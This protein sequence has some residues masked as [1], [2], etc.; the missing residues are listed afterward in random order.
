MPMVNSRLGDQV[1]CYHADLINIYNSDIGSR[2]KIGDFTEIGGATVGDDTSI[3]AFCYISPGT[4][5]GNRCSIG[6]RVSILNRQYGSKL[7]EEYKGVTIA[8]DVII[9]GDVTILAGVTVGRNAKIGAGCKVVS[10][11]MPHT[12]VMNMSMDN[13]GNAYPGWDF[14]VLIEKSSVPEIKEAVM[15]SGAIEIPNGV[16]TIQGVLFDDIINTTIGKRENGI[17]V[18]QDIVNA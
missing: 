1:V 7:E 12:T 13:R 5:I 9:G 11:V 18:E 8:D 17:K 10:D 6:P 2:V 4:F 14:G 3:G 16:F 15:P